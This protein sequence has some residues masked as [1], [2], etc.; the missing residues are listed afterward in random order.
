MSLQNIFLLAG[1]LF[2]LLVSVVLFAFL[3]RGKLS[4]LKSSAI[5]CLLVFLSC[6][7]YSVGAFNHTDFINQTSAVQFLLPAA[8]AVIAAILISFNLPAVL[9]KPVFIILPFAVCFAICD[10]SEIYQAAISALLWIL[11]CFSLPVSNRFAGVAVSPAICF[12]CGILVLSLIGAVPSA[13][14][15]YGVCLAAATAGFMLFNWPPAALNLSNSDAGV[16]GFLIGGIAACA[17]L[18]GSASSALIFVM[19]PLCEACFAVL[20]KVTFMPQ[21]ADLT[22]N[23]A[24]AK[25]VASGLDS[26]VLAKHAM[27]INIMMLLFGCLQAYAPDQHSIPLVCAAIVIWQM[28]RLIHWN[29]LSSGIGETNQN[30]IS[31]LK[32]NFT[33]IRTQIKEISPANPSKKTDKNN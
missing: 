6:A 29:N 17:S 7:A 32:K 19:F 27:R 16:L 23:T 12:G 1:G 25:A 26:A 20:Q 5:I 18:E 10:S 31:E 30:V 21:F 13:I 8:A 24:G 4:F 33:E 28:Y 22:A 3:N 11:I 14:G 15:F 2:C 9:L